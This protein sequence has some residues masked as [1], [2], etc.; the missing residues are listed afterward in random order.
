[1]PKN[2]P[3]MVLVLLFFLSGSCNLVYEVVWTRMFSL[4]FGV[5]VFAVSAVLA[6]FMLG[7]AAG[8][9]FF[10]RLADTA[11]NNCIVFSFVHIGIS[12]STV[13]LLLVFPLFGP[14]YLAIN[15]MF[16]QSYLTFRIIIFLFALV[17]MIVPTTLMGATFPVA[18]R[19]L[20]SRKDRMARD[21]GA[22]YSVNT[23]GSVV[24]CITAVFV[25]LGPLGMTITVLV[26]AG[27]DLA[28]GCAA[29]AVFRAFGTG[30]RT[31]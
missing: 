3:A 2:P 27:A 13:L 31:A 1:M 20:A 28:I 14:V 25:L 23:L 8:G 6:A 12:V 29:L 19:M 22:L 18:V 11:K 5:T 9:I 4:V 15:T 17:L 26:A 24:G 7:M 21:I 10:G 30:I 16:G